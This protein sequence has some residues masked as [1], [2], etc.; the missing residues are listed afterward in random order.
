MVSQRVK[1]LHDHRCQVCGLRLETAAG[2]YAEGAHIRPLG[3]PHNGP[4][5][6]EN[7]L[8]LCPNHHVLL[9]TGGIFIRADLVVVDTL[10]QQESTRLRT[11]PGHQVGQE[12]LSYHRRLFGREDAIDGPDEKSLD[13]GRRSRSTRRRGRAGPPDAQRA[14]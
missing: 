5:V 2:P 6:L 3:E 1:E 12:F 14:W 10:G 8:C 13:V 4:D 7:S 11:R 9:D